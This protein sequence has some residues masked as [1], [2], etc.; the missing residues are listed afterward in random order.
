MT[1][2]KYKTI[3]NVIWFLGELYSYDDSDIEGNDFDV[4]CETE[5]GADSRFSVLITDLAGDAR[6]VINSQQEEITAL[7]AQLGRIKDCS[8][9]LTNAH[10]QPVALDWNT[11]LDNLITAINNTPQQCLADVLADAIETALELTDDAYPSEV[12]CIIS[13]YAE[14]LRASK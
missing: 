9:K 7:K 8:E 4:V 5:L 6:G 13:D 1:S 14:Q 10:D 2:L 12:Y 3:D 11:R